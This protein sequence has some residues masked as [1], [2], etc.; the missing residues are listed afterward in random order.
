MRSFFF[1]LFSL[2]AAVS[3]IFTS[4]SARTQAASGGQTASNPLQI[5][6]DYIQAH[7]TDYGL[8]T[9]DLAELVVTDLYTS[10]ETGL[11]HVYLRQLYKGI[12]VVGANLN[13]NILPNGETLA[14]WSHFVPDL[15]ARVNTNTPG[16]SAVQAAQSAAGALGLTLTQ[17]L[18]VLNFE[19]A[20]N[21]PTTLSTG[22]I[23]LLPIPA[24]LVYEMT[25]DGKTARLAWDL[26]IYELSTLHYW[27]V[28]VDAVTGELL[29]QDDW[30]DHE[31]YTVYPVPVES[32]NH[33][34]PLPP[35][36]GR[37]LVNN[38]F[39]P[40]ASPFG[41]HDTNGVAGAEYTVTRGN[42]AY[43]YTDT[44]ADNLPD[45]GSSPD[46]G[47]GLAF[48]FPIDLTQPPSAYR[49]AAVTNLFYWNN[50]VHDV[51]YQY[52][53]NE[54]AGNFQVNNY[55]NGGLG[56]DSVNA[57]AQDG[58][59]TNNANFATP[60][61]GSA[62]R[63]QMYVGTNPNPDVDGDLDNMVIAHEYGHGISNR[64]T[65]GPNNV[66]CLGN[67]E[68]MGEGWS[69]Y[70]G[71]VLTA[72][73]SDT[74]TTARGVGTYLFGQPPNG[75]GIRP[76]PY[77]TDMG[78]NN[79]TYGDI[80]SLA[81]PHGVGFV[82]ASMVWEM[83][84]A[85]VDDYGFNSDFYGDWTTG[86]NNLA[87]QL[88]TDGMKI[89]PCSPGFV[90]GRDAILAADVALTGGVNQCT[91]WSAFAKRGLG[92]SA[93]QGS[94]NSTNDG[95]EAFD[96]PSS[97]QFVDVT[98]PVQNACVAT[99]VTYNVSV[100]SALVAPVTLSG[101]GNP[102]PSTLTFNPNPVNS[103]PSISTLTVGNTATAAS[104]S[105][106]LTI[107]ASDG[108]T[109]VQRTAE[110]NLFADV[111]AGVTLVSPVN[112][113]NGVSILPTLS[114]DNLTSATTYTV[115]VATDPAFTNI[116]YTASTQA[117]SHTLTDSLTGLTTYYWRVT[118]ANPCGPGVSSTVF[119]FTTQPA[120]CSNPGVPISDLTVVTDNLVLPD[121]GLIADVNLSI[122]ANHTWVGDLI[123]TLQ[124]DA[125]TVIAV[126]RPG[127]PASTFGCS[128]DNVG[129]LL[130]DEGVDGPVESQCSGTS[131]A[132]FGSP[133]PN[134]PLSAF[135]A[136]ST[137]LTWTL[138]VEDMV[139]GDT[140]TLNQWCIYL[141]IVDTTP[142]TTT[143]VSA[144]PDPDAN[145]TPTIT[146]SGD[147]GP[148]GSGVA[149]FECSLD[150]GG[151]AAC[152]S[153]YTTTS[154]VDGMHTFDVRAYDVAGNVDPTPASHSWTVDTTAPATPVLVSPADGTLTDDS[155]PTLTWQ[156][157][158]G[159]ASYLLDWNG[160]VM[161]VGNI[162]AY[163]TPL[164]ADGVYTWTVAAYDVVN[165]T[166]SYATTWNFT[167]DT[168]APSVPTL[169]GPADSAV[170]TDT[171]PKLVW[172]SVP[173]A[174][175]YLLNWNGVIMDVGNVTEFA[176][177]EL[178]AGE[179]YTW[180]VAA[181]DAAGNTSAYA[182][183]YSFSIEIPGSTMFTAWLPLIAKP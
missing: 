8:S 138:S 166:S 110:L 82:W 164:L 53:F 28:R 45:A 46:G 30:V 168:T 37:V 91:I 49:P 4:G 14:M 21:Q 58:S 120:F 17:P 11:T 152:T 108:V 117:D 18:T 63:M 71:L 124:H 137:A 3:L 177:P 35:A 60:P 144:P 64:L 61:D 161:D 104:G 77:T 81:I 122:D 78:V 26:S 16:L 79:Y 73:A 9:D 171:L 132:L 10:A 52:G 95:T 36:D 68:Q 85:L 121:L 41:W 27:S 151:F 39:D 140:G 67:S 55:G 32:P 162:S 29:A 127:V 136:V 47:G 22:G 38:P 20:A 25:N 118:A 175:G 155:T 24:R 23:S 125:T 109:T 86:G 134:N 130:D 7:R 88:V 165:N 148:L 183:T 106:T 153:P 142:P 116:I 114:W 145:T 128:S 170:L 179:T 56:S 69:D 31:S 169:L 160:V 76:A 89:Q 172:A 182:V 149:G 42:N 135:D 70:I 173:G 66:S 96:I 62:P 115:E 129:I 141:N 2:L 158:S 131:P 74:S 112:G 181:Y 133:T 34:A 150:G 12:E 98:P 48:T 176:T 92:F 113:G 143:L 72:R 87:I 99:D 51:F 97:C 105:Y 107:S 6:L 15:A 119:S 33:T 103:V 101:S 54:V 80:G 163:T 174:A 159:A 154:L 84:W 100:G 13:T 111:P 126:D 19:N 167:V 156:P 83:Y 75:P 157:S 146:F 40:T 57:E 50:I 90:D 139:A 178:A 102:A 180:S 93:S 147:D 59:G 43:A 1:R 123:F 5:A 65:G 44:N 94:S